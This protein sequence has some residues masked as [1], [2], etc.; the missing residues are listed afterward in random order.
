V[1]NMEYWRVGKRRLMGAG[2]CYQPVGKN[3][4]VLTTGLASGYLP[5]GD[6]TEAKP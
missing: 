4:T 2:S 1:A 6:A 5:E 3:A